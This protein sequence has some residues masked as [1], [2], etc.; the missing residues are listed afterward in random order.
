[1]LCCSRRQAAV[2][3]L[4]RWASGH[5]GEY[6]MA[7]MI[8]DDIQVFTTDGERTFYRFL[9]AVAKPDNRHLSWYLPDVQGREPDFILYSEDVGLVIFE[10]KDWVLDQIVQ[11]DPQYFILHIKGSEDK[12]RNPFQQ[13]HDYFSLI[14]DRIKEDGHLVSKEPYAHGNVK[15]PVNCGVVFPNINKFEYVHW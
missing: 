9:Q 1:M 13:A 2:L 6:A 3:S 12:R 14:L 10:V 11:A 15:I 8:P 4:F 5:N 7:T